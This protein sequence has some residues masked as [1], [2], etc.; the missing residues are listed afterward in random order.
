MGLGFVVAQ[1]GIFVQELA[2]GKTNP[3]IRSH[4]LSFPFGTVL[5][6]LGVAV[7]VISAW[8]HLRLHRELKGE[9]A[10]LNRTSALAVA[11]AVVLAAIGLAMIFGLV[12]AE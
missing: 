11:V 6:A 5:I 7:N 9:E 4:G 12:L 8:N 2:V 1:F 3:Q 10:A